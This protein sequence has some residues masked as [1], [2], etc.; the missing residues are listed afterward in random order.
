MSGRRLRCWRELKTFRYFAAGKN[1]GVWNLDRAPEP[2]AGNGD[3]DGGRLRR[4]STW[5]PKQCQEHNERRGEERFFHANLHQDRG[6]LPVQ[7]S[8][9]KDGTNIDS[10]NTRDPMGQVGPN[11]QLTD[12][13]A[14]TLT[15]EKMEAQ[16]V[17]GTE[18]GRD[19][20][21]VAPPDASRT[22]PNSSESELTLRGGPSETL[23]PFEPRCNA[24]TAK[25]ITHLALRAA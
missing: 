7:S 12:W 20:P 24:Q 5:N 23:K 14:F 2:P 10:V 8:T 15:N 16:N 9:L 11:T 4:R 22:Q 18:L 13:R 19:W 21:P 3:L 6:F 17:L 1:S 25:R